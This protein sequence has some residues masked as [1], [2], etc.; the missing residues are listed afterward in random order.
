MFFGSIDHLEQDRKLLTAPIVKGLEFL[1]NTALA[2]LELGRH[3]IDGDNVYALVQEYQTLPKAEKKVEA[4]RKYIDIQYIVAGAEVIGYGLDSPQNEVTEDKLAEKDAIFYKN[5]AGEM[6]LIL[7]KG[8]YAVL[9]PTDIH[10]PGCN[11][12]AGGP[13]RKVV[14]KVAL[15]R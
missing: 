2:E 5:I 15:N 12:G 6:D 14:V 8:M 3:E 9:F 11:Y 4:H 1:K 10:R 7:S 13:V